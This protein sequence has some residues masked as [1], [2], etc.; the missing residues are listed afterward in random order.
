M[1][2]LST[3]LNKVFCMKFLTFFSV[4]CTCLLLAGCGGSGEDNTVAPIN[5]VPVTPATPIASTANT[6]A[7]QGHTFVTFNELDLEANNRSDNIATVA[8]AD[9]NDNIIFRA[10]LQPSQSKEFTLSIAAGNNLYKVHWIG[11][12][13]N[14]DNYNT[15]TQEVSDVTNALTFEGFY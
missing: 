5:T 2:H 10:S 14:I 3:Q 6:N 9:E 12:D 1:K 11:F 7:A 8:I 4:S 15:F 13:T